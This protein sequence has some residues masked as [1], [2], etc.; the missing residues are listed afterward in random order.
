M[1]RNKSGGRHTREIHPCRVMRI[2][3]G[4][5]ANARKILVFRHFYIL[6]I[7]NNRFLLPCWKAVIVIDGK[8]Y[9]FGIKIQAGSKCR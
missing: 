7:Y 8:M 3:P 1:R 5:W 6:R 2:V 9:V 4:N